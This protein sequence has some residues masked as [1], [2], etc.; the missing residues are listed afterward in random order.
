MQFKYVAFTY[1]TNDVCEYTNNSSGTMAK[2]ISNKDVSGS[3]SYNR[4]DYIE[5]NVTGEQMELALDAVQVY[6]DILTQSQLQAIYD[7]QI[8]I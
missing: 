7:M 5:H 1:T 6:S 2:E 8:R 4:V 3:T